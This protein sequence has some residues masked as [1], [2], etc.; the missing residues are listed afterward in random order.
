MLCTC[1]TCHMCGFARV[2][3]ADGNMVKSPYTA[4]WLISHPCLLCTARQKVHCCGGPAAHALKCS[5]NWATTCSHVQSQHHMLTCSH[6]QSTTRASLASLC[7]F[8][9]LRQTVKV[10]MQEQAESKSEDGSQT[11]DAGTHLVLLL[12]YRTFN[13][14]T[15]HNTISGFVLL[16]DQPHWSGK[17]DG[18]DFASSVQNPAFESLHSD[19]LHTICGAHT[20]HHIITLPLPRPPARPLNVHCSV[21]C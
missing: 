17:L 3:V 2:C 14:V 4:S 13:K 9:K 12:S 7:N 15:N 19:N 20:T 6:H 16:K 11:G 5:P 18:Y 1:H 10:C 21:R 8:L